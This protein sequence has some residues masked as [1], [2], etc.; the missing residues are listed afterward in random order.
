MTQSDG[1]G[2][3]IWTVCSRAPEK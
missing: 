2:K 1:L 3:R